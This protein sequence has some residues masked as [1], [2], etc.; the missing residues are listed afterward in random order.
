MKVGYCHKQLEGGKNSL[1][2]NLGKTLKS[3]TTESKYSS[4]KK[5]PLASLARQAFSG[6]GGEGRLKLKESSWQE[7]KFIRAHAENKFAENKRQREAFESEQLTTI[8]HPLHWH[9]NLSCSQ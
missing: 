6:A 5:D 8:G 9:S 7:I 2:P 3:H 1:S 4:L